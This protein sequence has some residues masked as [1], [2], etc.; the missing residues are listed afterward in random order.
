MKSS[1][2]PSRMR[3]GDFFPLDGEDVVGNVAGV[4]RASGCGDKENE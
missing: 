2:N 4:R 1:V 3:H